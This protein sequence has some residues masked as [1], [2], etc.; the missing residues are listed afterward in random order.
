M[1]APGKA[2][3]VQDKVGVH[4][5]L[6][7]VSPVLVVLY[8]QGG[9]VAAVIHLLRWELQELVEV[10]VVGVLLV[11]QDKALS[12]AYQHHKEEQAQQAGQQGFM[13]E[14]PLLLRGRLRAL[15]KVR[16]SQHKER[17]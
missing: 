10:V 15:A 3:V 13:P 16:L 9:Q 4:P 6:Q 14:E 8:Q 5:L 2:V 1:E 17:L 11:L 12:R 7:Q